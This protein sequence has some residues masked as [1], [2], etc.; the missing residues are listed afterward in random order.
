MPKVDIVPALA[1]CTRASDTEEV[2]MKRPE[3]ENGMKEA[4]ERGF[5]GFTISLFQVSTA[6]LAK[7]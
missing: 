1:H 3:T 6:M 7:Y 5:L 2:A 4:N